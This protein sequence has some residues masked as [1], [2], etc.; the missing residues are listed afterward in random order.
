[1]KQNAKNDFPQIGTLIESLSK[2]SAAISAA[3]ES[4]FI[5]LDSIKTILDE[6]VVALSQSA[7][8]FELGRRLLEESIQEIKT[9][10]RAVQIVMPGLLDAELD[11]MDMASL[12]DYDQLKRLRQKINFQFDR[13]FDKKIASGQAGLTL[14]IDEFK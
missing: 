1:M 9:K 4:G 13:I 3:P 8:K 10:S 7:P 14:K 2:A 11:S 6:T 5:D 12:S